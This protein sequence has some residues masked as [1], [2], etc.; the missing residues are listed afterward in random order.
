MIERLDICRTNESA[1]IFVR[2]LCIRLV[3][4]CCMSVYLCECLF[5]VGCCCFCFVGFFMCVFVC[6]CVFWYGECACLREIAG[7]DGIL[8][9]VTRVL[10][11]ASISVSMSCDEA[12]D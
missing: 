10:V 12:C 8:L 1:Y 7:S 9:L 2:V 11:V 3:S 6:M 4:N 5:C